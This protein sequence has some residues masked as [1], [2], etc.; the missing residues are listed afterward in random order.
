MTARRQVTLIVIFTAFL[1][2]AQVV[3]LMLMSQL[4]T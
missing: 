2:T 1:F 4:P 3:T